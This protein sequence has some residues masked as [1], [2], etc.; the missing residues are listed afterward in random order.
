MRSI[1]RS[2]LLRGRRSSRN[3]AAPCDIARK[4]AQKDRRDD[5][6]TRVDGDIMAKG[7]RLIWELLNLMKLPNC[8][9]QIKFIGL[10]LKTLPCVSSVDVEL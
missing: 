3:W 9:T 7:V 4:R 6:V 5:V 2:R 10:E 1:W 8:C